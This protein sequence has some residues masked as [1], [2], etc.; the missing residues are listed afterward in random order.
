M[1]GKY[2]FLGL[3]FNVVELG[4]GLKFITRK[5]NLRIF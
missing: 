5:L 1:E 2:F 4:I 3:G